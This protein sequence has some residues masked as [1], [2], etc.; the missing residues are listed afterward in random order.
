MLGPEVLQKF[1]S[2]VSPDRC[3]TAKEDLL[4]YGYDARIYEY[5]PEAV[6]FSNGCS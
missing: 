1:V 5:L 3:K 6:L 4:T 2:I